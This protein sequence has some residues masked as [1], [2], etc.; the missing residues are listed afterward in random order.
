M[1]NSE[2]IQFHVVF[3]ITDGIDFAREVKRLEL[4]RLFEPAHD[5]C[6]RLS[7]QNETLR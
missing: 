1:R 4:H 3:R 5:V 7:V 6:P 2:F